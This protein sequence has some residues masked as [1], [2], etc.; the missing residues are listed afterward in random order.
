[1]KLLTLT[2]DIGSADFLIGAMKGQLL[3][4]IQE[5]QLVDITHHLPSFNYPHTA[6]IGKNTLKHFPTG[7]FHL[8]LVNLFNSPSDKILLAEHNGHFIGC[9]DNGL[10][11]MILEDT[12]QKVVAL[13]TSKIQQQNVLH[14]VR[15]F[16]TAIQ[17][18][19]EGETLEQ[20]GELTTD[21]LVR[22]PIHPSFGEN[23][24]EGQIIYIDHF[25]NVIVNITKPDFEAHRKGRQFSI[26][27]KRD[28]TIDRISQ[29]YA[30]VNEGAKLA[31]FNAAG[32]LEI[33]VN[34]G[35]AGGLFGLQGISDNPFHTD[36][37]FYQTVKIFFE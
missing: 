9:A 31:F 26:V 32:Y 29:H 12:P 6:Y 3:Q 37:I 22:N 15:M 25:E 19:T 30:D 17:R 23:W 2:T 14:Y 35:N 7:T 36:R 11:T 13:D 27:F 8:F 21:Y 5:V 4:L 34:K 33:A 20:L 10:L 28:E 1:M 18:L 16:G 24:I